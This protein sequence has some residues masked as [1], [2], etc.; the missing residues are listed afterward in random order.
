MTMEPREKVKLSKHVLDMK[1]MKRSKEKVQK[2]TEEEE[3]KSILE[4]HVIHDLKKEGKKFIM[5]PSFGPC[6]EL[7]SGRMSF[8]GMNPEIERIM[9]ERELA[10]NPNQ[11]KMDGISDKEMTERYS[12]LI[13]TIAKKFGKKR[14]RSESVNKKQEKTE[15]ESRKRKFRKPVDE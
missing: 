2:E 13:G 5:E 1:F 9:A 4:N 11:H 6:E 7:V 10:A 3:R 12:S 14:D 15:N 8:K